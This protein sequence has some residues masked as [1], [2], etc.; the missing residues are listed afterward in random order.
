[1]IT[2][3]TPL[4]TYAMSRK[5]WLKLKKEMPEAIDKGLKEGKKFG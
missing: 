1:M 4:G 5:Q 2:I 3:N